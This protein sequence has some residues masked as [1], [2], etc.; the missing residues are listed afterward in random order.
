MGQGFGQQAACEDAL[1]ELSEA[2]G[3]FRTPTER[4]LRFMNEGLQKAESLEGQGFLEDAARLKA[5]TLGQGMEVY[6]SV[7]SQ[8]NPS[9]DALDKSLEKLDLENRPVQSRL[10]ASIPTGDHPRTDPGQTTPQRA[11]V[12]P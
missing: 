8:A 3:E 5:H 4:A 12:C 7:S 10:K 9:L 1:R 2:D 6:R 11:P